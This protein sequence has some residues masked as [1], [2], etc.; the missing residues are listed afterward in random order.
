MDRQFLETF[1]NTFFNYS[2]SSD[3]ALF[4]L[5]L[6]LF[7]LTAVLAGVLFN[8]FFRH[9]ESRLPTNLIVDRQRID[10]ILNNALQ[11]RAKLELR[12]AHEDPAG[13]RFISGAFVEI[14]KE[15]VVLELSDLVDVSSSW[16]GRKIEAFFKVSSPRAGR[17][18]SKHKGATFFTFT[19]EIL[20]IKKTSEEYVAVTVAF[21]HSIEAKQ[22]RTHLRLDPPS[23]LIYGVNLWKESRTAMGK[24][25]S[26]ISTWEAPLLVMDQDVRDTMTLQNISAGGIRLEIQPG[27]QK[28]DTD[29]FELGKRFIVRLD[30]FNPTENNV[31]RHYLYTVVRN[32][33]EDFTT[34]KLEVGLKF[35]ATG[36]PSAEDPDILH[37]EVAKG[38]N[39]VET[40]DNWVFKRHLELYRNTGM[41]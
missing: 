24:V 28:E 18:K 36:Y 29:I 32:K 5:G 14:G 4:L 10:K 13:G 3:A 37:W 27:W 1:K 16:I 25:N 31:D 39:G 20:G 9:K 34:H 6:L 11:E 30:L 21:P 8:K 33:Y 26:N 12:F 35:L 40:I 19:V 41:A 23:S 38:E 15:A 22:K 2:F 17:K 7:L